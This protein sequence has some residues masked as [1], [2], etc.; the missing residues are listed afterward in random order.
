M[1]D[2]KNKKIHVFEVFIFFENILL[3]SVSR[4]SLQAPSLVDIILRNF[5]SSNSTIL[6]EDLI[7][8][9]RCFEIFLID[10]CASDIANKNIA[11]KYQSFLVSVS[12]TLY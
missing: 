10:Q 8:W 1:T 5:T 2:K 6:V 4:N 3:L 7:R 9:K 11:G 12:A